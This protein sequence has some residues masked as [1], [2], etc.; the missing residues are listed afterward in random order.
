MWALLFR[1]CTGNYSFVLLGPP[2]GR[3]W[4]GLRNVPPSVKGE[5]PGAF[6]QSFMPVLPRWRVPRPG[7]PPTWKVSLGEM[8]V[9]SQALKKGPRQRRGE[10]ESRACRTA[11]DSAVVLMS[12][13]REDPGMSAEAMSLSKLF[14]TPRLFALTVALCHTKG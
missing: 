6:V 12:G 1:S 11:H 5:G 3:P 13:T 9:A 14:P 2:V 7:P 10:A 4:E 8:G